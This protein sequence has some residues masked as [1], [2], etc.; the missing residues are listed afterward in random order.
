[1]D[2]PEL[3]EEISNA[4]KDILSSVAHIDE[5]HYWMVIFEKDNTN[6]PHFHYSL[7]FNQ[8]GEEKEQEDEE[9][10]DIDDMLNNMDDII[11]KGINQRE[12]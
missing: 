9:I 3:T 11:H 8:D 2:A 4:I 6:K 7:K 12:E 10:N 1:M 5:K